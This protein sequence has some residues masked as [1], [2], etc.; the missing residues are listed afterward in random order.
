[1]QVAFVVVMADEEEG[2]P[3]TGWAQYDAWADGA[4]DD[5]EDDK[6]Y[7]FELFDS[8]AEMDE[9]LDK[10]WGS[11]MMQGFVFSARNGTLPLTEE[12]VRKIANDDV[13]WDDFRTDLIVKI[14]ENRA[15]NTYNAARRIVSYDNWKYE[16][17]K[18]MSRKYPSHI[19]D[20]VIAKKQKWTGIVYAFAIEFAK[21]LEGSIATG[22]DDLYSDVVQV[23]DKHS[24]WMPADENSKRKLYYIAGFLIRAVVNNAKQNISEDA[25]ELFKSMASRNKEDAIASELPTD[26]VEKREVDNLLFASSAFFDVV[27]KL[28]C[29]FHH[30]LGEKSIE[31]FGPQIIAD[32]EVCLNDVDIGINSLVNGC[33]DNDDVVNIRKRVIEAYCNMRGKDYVRQRRALSA[34]NFTESHRSTIGIIAKQAKDNAEKKKAEEENNNAVFDND[35]NVDAMICRELKAEL[36]KRKLFV[37]GN[38]GE[39]QQRLK[40]DIARRKRAEQEGE[41]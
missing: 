25:I 4:G 12:T 17:I 21:T 33:D 16:Y 41:G 14:F 29:V 36:K 27:I 13:A 23:L 30:I 15:T 39:L 31:K 20:E 38:K 40:D 10:S 2:R 24:T 19:R 34:F 5:D 3:P 11:S 32:L 26:D 18:E 35:I 28:E 8:A 37:S 1:M 6:D 22:G 9:C 7:L